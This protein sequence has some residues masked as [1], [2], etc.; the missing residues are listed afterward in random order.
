MKVPLEN[1]QHILVD[2]NML[3]ILEQKN[4]Q[5]KMTA[6]CLKVAIF[7]STKCSTTVDRSVSLKK[8]KVVQFF[9]E[10]A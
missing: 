9:P 10:Q 3:H 1:T 8:I 7:K 6:I 4:D 2:L 5:R